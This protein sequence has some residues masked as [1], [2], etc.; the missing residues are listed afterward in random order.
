M[1]EDFVLLKRELQNRTGIMLDTIS[2]CKKL[3]T[4]LKLRGVYIS[5][6]TLSRLF[7]LANLKT[8]PRKSTLDEL[9]TV[10]GY[11][12]FSNFIFEIR[13]STNHCE[14]PLEL[15]FDF[16]RYL[17]E[18]KLEL[19]AS[20]YLEMTT[21]TAEAKLFSK[22]LAVQLFAQP[23]LNQSALNLLAN[24]ENGR[25][26]FF[27]TYIDED[28]ISGNYQRSLNDF[29]LTDAN[30]EE[31]L[32]SQLFLLRKKVLSGAKIALK[33]HPLLQINQ[34]GSIHLNARIIELQLISLRN[35]KSV[36]KNKKME[37]VFDS[38]YLQLLKCN[39]KPEELALLG[40]FARGLLFSGATNF[41]RFH[42]KIELAMIESLKSDFTDFEFQ[43][44]IYAL[45]RLH[46]PF[47]P[48]RIP[49]ASNWP[50]AY[51]SSIIFI[52]SKEKRKQYESF[53]F[54][55]IGIHRN[56]LFAF[57]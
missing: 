1:N 47:Q 8:I 30:A 5:Y 43:I 12:N 19:A 54:H 20:L 53:F 13:N 29:F 45:L 3:D 44:P 11:A 7:N 26:Y 22:D 23:T 34:L 21:I 39:N 15:Q 57:D 25:A 6:S 50:N 46:N 31:E 27:Q 28:D 40:R 24:S 9:A 17:A 4:W 14:L 33:N 56:F 38:T 36:E 35:L 2:G 18:N 41:I 42:K 10:L 51:Y 55:S 16:E 49:Q 32:F 37:Q 52:L 48:L